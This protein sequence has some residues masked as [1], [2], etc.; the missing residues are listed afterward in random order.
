MARQYFLFILALGE[1]LCKRDPGG[2]R[3][4]AVDWPLLYLQAERNCRFRFALQ[5]GT[6]TNN[7]LAK[8]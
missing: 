6:P 3:A 8:F 1:A 2:I 5:H 4:E 7:S